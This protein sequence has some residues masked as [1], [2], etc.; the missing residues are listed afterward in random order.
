[1]AQSKVWKEGWRNIHHDVREIRATFPV[2]AL[3]E[4]TVGRSW[5]PEATEIANS[6]ATAQASHFEWRGPHHR[7]D[8]I[9]RTGAD[10]AA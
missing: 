8:P 1:V 6:V 9:P 3:A 5:V 7:P 10:S 2:E 4:V